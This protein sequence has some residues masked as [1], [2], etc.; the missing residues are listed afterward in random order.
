MRTQEFTLGFDHE[1]TRTMSFG[2]RYAHK[3]LDR[4]IEDVGIAGA[5]R[6]RGVLRS[7][8]RA[9][10]SAEI[11]AARHGCPTCPDAAEGEA[12]LTTASSSGCASAERTAGRLTPATCYSRLY[13]NYSGLASS[14]E[15]GRTSP[16]VDRYFDGL[17]MSFDQ[18]GKPL[19][20]RCRPIVR[21]TFKTQTTYDLPWG[22]RLGVTSCA[23]SGTPQQSR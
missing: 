21:T 6:R 11:L 23:A 7:P 8:T 20:G 16:N 18:T 4:T 13:G 12:R 10:A 15:N 22:T 3:W 14:D 9:S 1:L 5:R 2:V 19:Y 17:Y